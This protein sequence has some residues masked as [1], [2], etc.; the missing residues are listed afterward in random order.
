MSHLVPISLMSGLKKTD[1]ISHSLL[2]SQSVGLPVTYQPLG[3]SSE[4]SRQN[5]KEGAGKS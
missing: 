4:Y 3:Y 5:E 2:P 1:V